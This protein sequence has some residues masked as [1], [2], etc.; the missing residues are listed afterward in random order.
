MDD[1]RVWREAYRRYD[2]DRAVS[3]ETGEEEAFDDWGYAKSEREAFVAGVRWA[4]TEKSARLTQDEKGETD[5][6]A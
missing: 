5:A 4:L 1:E 6:E 2:G 3:E